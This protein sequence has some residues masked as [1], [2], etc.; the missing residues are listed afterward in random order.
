MVASQNT[1]AQGRR[2]ALLM[3]NTG[4]ANVDEELLQKTII[5]VGEELQRKN[6]T[7]VTEEDMDEELDG[8]SGSFSED[9]EEE[10]NNEQQIFV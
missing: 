1:K 10:K 3:H 6:S 7:L 8:N 2:K 4:E 9:E 5:A